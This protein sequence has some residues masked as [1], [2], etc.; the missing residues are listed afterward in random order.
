MPFKA[1][2]VLYWDGEELAQSLTICRFLA[3]KAGLAGRNELEQAQ[4]DMVIDHCL[5]AFLGKSKQ[6]KFEVLQRSKK[7]LFS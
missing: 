6:L 4:V 2:P 7:L 3:K 5:D 1:L